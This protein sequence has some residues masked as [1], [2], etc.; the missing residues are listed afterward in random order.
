MMIIDDD[1]N[2]D[3]D[4]NGDDDDAGGQYNTVVL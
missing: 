3:H 4:V 2:G 1:E